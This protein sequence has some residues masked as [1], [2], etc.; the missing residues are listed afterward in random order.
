MDAYAD[1]IFCVHICGNSERLKNVYRYG[2]I[3]LWIP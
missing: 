1:V 2:I 3:E